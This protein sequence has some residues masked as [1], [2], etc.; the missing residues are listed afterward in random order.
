MMRALVCKAFGPAEELVVEDWPEPVPGPGEVLIDVRA[1]ALNFPDSLVIQGK[2][3]VRTEPPFVPGSE[4]A[5]VIAAVGDDVKGFHTGDRVIAMTMTGAFAERCA[6]PAR[7]VMPLPKGLDFVGGAGFLITQA[8]SLHA[9]RQGAGLKEGE[10]LLVLG[11]AGGVGSTA[12]ELGKL[13][14]ARVIAAAS[15]EEK[16]AFSR[17]AGAD[18]TIDYSKTSLKD[19]VKRL[20]GDKGVDVVYDPVGGDLAQQALRALAWHGRHLVV[21]FASGDIPAF[22]ANIALLKEAR[23]VGVFWGAWAERH[24]EE[25]RKNL[26]DLAAWA[27]EGKIASRVTETFALEDY[28]H[29]F[30]RLTGRQAKGKIV[31]TLD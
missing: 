9:L 19:E 14:G 13:L 25:S 12:V 23:I 24:P 31:F 5:G 2:Y 20:T 28:A 18:E 8:T 29:A 7:R 17:D 3:Q 26:A 1:A 6:V 30:G 21:G 4:A 15:S 16:L 10:T 27:T 22:P 11:A